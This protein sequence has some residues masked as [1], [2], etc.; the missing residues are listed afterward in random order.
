MATN[1]VTAGFQGIPET[2]NNMVETIESLGVQYGLKALGAVAIF[3]IGMWASKQLRKVIVSLMHRS[4]VDETLITFV[5][6]LAH[7]ALQVFVI[8][9]ALET[10]DVKT[11][12]F[13]AVLGAAG[14]AV[15]LALQGSLS[16]FAA[17]VLM[18][19]FKPFRV[20]EVVDAGGVL[21]TVREI[22]IF[23]TVI[24]TLDNRKTIIPNAKMTSDNIVNYSANNTR[25]VDIVAGISYGDDIDKARAAIKSVL[26]EVP[27]IL[28]NPAPDI[29]VSEMA[30]SSV[31][32]AVR[33][34]CR[35]SDYWAVYFGVTEAIKKKFDAE[36][37]TIPFP[38]RDVHLYEHKGE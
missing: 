35:P 8:I 9:A 27:G 21:G 23:T 38:Q 32:F 4:K 2:Y 13:I 24:D 6:S 19:I 12:S 36:D 37:I 31:N 10:L 16:N 26:A 7:V 17:G 33:P 11:T 15:G 20:G 18:I 28:E 14:L 3:I 22:G 29:F 30:D 25:R 1:N 34:W 5:A